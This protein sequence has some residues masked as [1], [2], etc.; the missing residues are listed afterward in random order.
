MHS[1][2]FFAVVTQGHLF[3]PNIVQMIRQCLY[4][5]SYVISLSGVYKAGWS[6]A[7]VLLSRKYTSNQL[8]FNT[9]FTFG[10]LNFL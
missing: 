4:K 5:I 3:P 9:G 6:L 7:I 1:D 2:F 8:D 10:S